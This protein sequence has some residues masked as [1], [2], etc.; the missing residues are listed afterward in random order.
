VRA[1][2]G[3]TAFVVGG[4][5]GAWTFGVGVTACSSPTTGPARAG[6]EA[7]ADRAAGGDSA[8]PEDASMPGDGPA[9]ADGATS[10]DGAVGTDAATASDASAADGA[11]GNGSSYS[12]NFPLT[13]SPISE[14]AH[15]LGGATAGGNLSGNVETTPGVAFGVSEPT[16]YGDPIAILTGSWGPTQMATATIKV[17]TVAA[18]CC[19][20]VEL[21]VRMTISL[22]SITGYEINCSVS[23]NNYLQIV[24]WNGP[25]GDYTYLNT[26]ATSCVDGDVLKA[27]VSGANPTTITVFKN[28]SQVLTASDTGG[29]AGGPGSAAGPWVTGN[30]GIGFYDDVDSDWNFFGFKTFAA[31]AQ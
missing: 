5:I 20:E 30:P 7:G 29:V 10:T 8:A 2:R 21:H 25:N 9:R 12:T 28:G 17:N 13:E 11:D 16:T 4:V 18:S 15:W 31:T 1:G 27:T 6:V 19:H 3:A 22:N 26:L 23:N 24:R 14:G